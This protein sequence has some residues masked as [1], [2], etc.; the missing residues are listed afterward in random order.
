MDYTKL[1]TLFSDLGSL[2]GPLAGLCRVLAQGKVQDSGIE[3]TLSSDNLTTSLA[4]TK[5][6]WT[7]AKGLV[8][9]IKA[10]LG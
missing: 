4:R 1:A 7:E 2:C 8:A 10:E 9:Q 6:K 5:E 3:I